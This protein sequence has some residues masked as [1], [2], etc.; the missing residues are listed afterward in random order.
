MQ[1]QPDQAPKS[2]GSGFWLVGFFLVFAVLGFGD[3]AYLTIEHFANV[4]PPCSATSGC[5]TVLT[6]R[7]ATIG[8]VP[9]ALLGAIYYL[10]MVVL[11]VLYLDTR[12]G[13]WLRYAT[14]IAM[15]GFIATI[16]L[17]C[18]QLF[19]LHAICLYCMGSA[20]FTTALFVSGL[21]IRRK[22]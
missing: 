5:E 4:I 7:F 6:S 8:P 18:L 13:A 10:A 14:Y 16:V 17:V 11:T 21:T 20:A 1:A 9:L 12:T 2:N 3:A 22:L 19:V 15:A